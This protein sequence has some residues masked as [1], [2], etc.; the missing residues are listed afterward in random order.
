MSIPNETHGRTCIIRPAGKLD[1][2]IAAEL[3]ELFLSVV[4]DGA[5]RLVVD[6]SGVTHMSS[7]GLKAILAV[8]RRLDPM[9]GQLALA[10]V[11][12]PVRSLLEAGGFFVLLPEYDTVNEAVAALLAATGGDELA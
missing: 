6:F 8:I 5:R 11:D 12:E 4:D 7:E 1:R 2:L 9:G 3:D 10:A